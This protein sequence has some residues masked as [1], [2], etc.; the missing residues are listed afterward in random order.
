M[1]LLAA[2]K[3][4]TNLK[5]LVKLNLSEAAEEHALVLSLEAK[6]GSSVMNQFTK[7]HLATHVTNEVEEYISKLRK[8][9]RA[10]KEERSLFTSTSMTE[11]H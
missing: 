10:K 4:K 6:I 9:S 7:L 5:N 2:T 1:F 8:S 3:T 11:V